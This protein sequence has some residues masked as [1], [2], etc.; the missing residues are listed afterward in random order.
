METSTLWPPPD[1]WRASLANLATRRRRGCRRRGLGCLG[2]LLLLVLGA[3]ILLFL[4][5]QRAQAAAPAAVAS[6]AAPTPTPANLAVVLLIDNS[7]SL[8]EKGGVGSDPDLLRLDAARLFISYLG[9]DDSRQSHR[10]SVIFFGETAEIVVPLTRLTSQQQRQELFGRIQEPE[11][12]G[13]TNPVLALAAARTALTTEATEQPVIVLLTDGK[14]EWTSAPTP[15]ERQAYLAA[16]VQESQ[17]LAAAQIPVFVILLANET[18]DADPEISDVW[19]PTWEALAATTPSGRVYIARGP[20]DLAGIYHNIVI[21]LTGAETEGPVLTATVGPAGLQK[22]INIEAGLARIIFVVSKSN[23]DLSVT[24]L[25]PDGSP[26][27]VTQ[28]GVRHA[29]QTGL[30]REEVWVVD[31]PLAGDWQ[32][33]ISGEGSVTV[34]KDFRAAPPTP[35]PAP[36]ATATNTPWPT[37]TA[38]PTPTPTTTPTPTPTPALQV[39]GMPEYTLVGQPITLTARVQHPPHFSFQLLLS[40][41]PPA[42]PVQTQRL[43]DDGHAGDK[44]AGDTL[45]GGVFTPT[46]PGEY[47]ATLQLVIRNQVQAVWEARLIAETA[48]TL[49]ITNERQ[50]TRA[51]QTLDMTADW[52]LAGQPLPDNQIV[53]LQSGQ[54]TLTGSDGQEQQFPLSMGADGSLAVQLPPQQPGVYTI[55][56]TAIAQTHHGQL[57]TVT[58]TPYTLSVTSPI[59]NWALG[60][61]A[62]LLASGVGGWGYRRWQSQKPIVLGTLVLLNGTWPGTASSRAELEQLAQPEIRVGCPPAQLPLH[63]M[64]AQ[65]AIRP[66][67]VIGQSREM[68]IRG[69]EGLLLNDVPLPGEQPL[70]DNSLITFGPHRLRYEN[71]LLRRETRTTPGWYMVK[72]IDS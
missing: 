65:F 2:I 39:Q 7:N 44:L 42:G 18:T 59:S 49:V 9:V 51:G 28:S 4:L 1:T 41:L 5:T 68:L 61:V 6:T 55:T 40:A 60:V 17:Q 35:T 32:L 13:W 31:N 50:R 22:T 69:P 29:G 67:K 36:T 26:L 71:L 70:A 47:L 10:C 14:P 66:G 11:R 48:P 72:P 62:L 20:Q 43:L 54:A 52:Q 23:P 64:P 12:M 8:F 27:A 25:Q 37:A 24:I 21:T 45:Y 30:T 15:D 19:L 56:L 16:L 63:E 53:A 46:Q 33:F 57:I 34:W 58:T 3:C 38:T